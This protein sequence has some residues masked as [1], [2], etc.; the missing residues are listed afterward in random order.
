[1]C[2]LTLAQE[3]NIERM[4]VEAR[5]HECTHKFMWDNYCFVCKEEV[6]TKKREGI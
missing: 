2:R 5:I 3:I 4:L 1:M 6:G